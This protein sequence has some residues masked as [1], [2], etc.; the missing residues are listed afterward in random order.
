MK[1]IDFHTIYSGLSWIIESLEY[2]I[3]DWA[4]SQKTK[5]YSRSQYLQG[6]R[7]L[8]DILGNFRMGH[9]E[10]KGGI[11]EIRGV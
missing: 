9:N 1:P 10:G 6:V 5:K 4:I 7:T 2:V 3:S 11:F 8:S